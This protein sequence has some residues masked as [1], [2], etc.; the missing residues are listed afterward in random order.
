M[1]QVVKAGATEPAKSGR[2]LTTRSGFHFWVRPIRAA[3][4]AALGEFF[5]HVADED[6]RFRFLSAVPRVGH[7]LLAF[8]TDVDHDRTENFLAFEADGTTVIATAML[9][10]DPGLERAEVA[11]AVR[12]DYKQRGISWTLLEHVAR[13]ARAKGIKKLESIE[14]RDNHQA[15]ELEREM[16]FAA[17]GYPGDST[18]VL[19]EADLGAR[20]G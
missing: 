2:I 10:A 15:I 13:A 4:E 12:A 20:A 11:L 3:D 6:L 18:L 5:T 1:L 17:A 16:G 19:L 9:A 8:L 14:S 7:D